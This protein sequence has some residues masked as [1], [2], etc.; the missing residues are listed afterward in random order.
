MGLSQRVDE[1]SPGVDAFRRPADPADG[2]V[3]GLVS[4]LS[5]RIS[6]G[7]ITGGQHLLKQCGCQQQVVVLGQWG[8][9]WV[10][11][12]LL[13]AGRGAKSDQVTLTG[14]LSM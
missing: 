12:V 8:H 11:E 4:R 10:A 7:E 1:A 6:G 2:P 13:L 3:V 5:F 9:S 14:A